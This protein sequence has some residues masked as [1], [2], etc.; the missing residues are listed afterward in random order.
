MVEAAEAGSDDRRGGFRRFGGQLIIFEI[1]FLGPTA[2]HHFA[3]L[4]SQY[5]HREGLGDH[6]HA[7]LE[8][9]AAKAAFSA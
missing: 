1:S 6:L 7:W 5:L 4:R 9:A 8:E 2:L 3:D